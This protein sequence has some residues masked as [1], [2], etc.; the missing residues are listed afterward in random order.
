M[1]GSEAELCH[2]FVEL[3]TELGY[4]AHCEVSGWDV[5]L[6]APNGEQIG[7]QAKLRANVDVLAQALGHDDM[8]GPDVHAVLV[9]DSS[10]AFKYVAKLIRVFVFDGA[11]LERWSFDALAKIPRWKHTAREWVPEV[12]VPNPA[13]V[14]APKSITPWK[15]AAVK[16]CLSAR[17]NGFVTAKMMRELKL[18]TTWWF[19]P[20]SGPALIRRARGQ[21]TL[22]DPA[23][24]RMPDLKWP[25]IA[26]A[27]R[28]KS[29]DSA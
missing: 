1:F 17:E 26:E 5:L 25:E 6:V 14:P 21:Y 13:G 2:R 4:V 20:T 27:L 23:D 12:L 15:M 29:R 3:A 16:L 11:W 28:S 19:A 18:S 22:R 7:V 10:A 8:P 9:P 24:P